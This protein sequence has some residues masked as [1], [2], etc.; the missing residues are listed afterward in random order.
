[1]ARPSRQLLELLERLARARVPRHD[2]R[3]AWLGQL[4]T[5]ERERAHVVHE[6]LL[7]ASAAAH[8]RRRRIEREHRLRGVI[9][10]VAA[11]GL[12]AERTLRALVAL[13]TR[14]LCCANVA[15]P[16]A[17]GHLGRR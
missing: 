16:R 3:P 2:A 7:A 11:A 5:G 8:A 10:A 13:R 17:V 14:W 9:V 12:E 4:D 6:L 15:E 1:M